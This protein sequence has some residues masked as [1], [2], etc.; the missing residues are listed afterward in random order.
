M[1]YDLLVPLRHSFGPFNLFRYI[2]FRAAA[3]GAFSILLVLLIGPV[4]I[5]LIKRLNIGQNIRTEVPGRHQAKAGT[6]T[7]GG[8]L[9]LAAGFAGVLLFADLENRQIQLGMLVLL[10]LGMLGFVDDFV[11]VK[12]RRPRGLSKTAKLLSQLAL[13]LLV[14]A[15]VWFLSADPV[16]RSRSNVL[17]FKNIVV[18]FGYFYVPFVM[19]VIVAGSNAVNLTDGLDGLAAGLLTIAL[20]SYGVLCYAAGNFKLA[21]YLNIM[22]VPTG[23]EMAVFCFALAGACLGFLWF[24]AHPAQIFMGDTGSLPLGGFLALAAVLCKHEMLLPLVGGVFVM[25]AGS[26]L[27][28]VFYF[29]A[30]RG[31]RLFRMAPIHHHFELGGWSEPQV[32]ARLTILAVLF[33]LGALATLKIR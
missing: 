3:A 13:A 10:W 24:N 8:L 14:G 7:M 18:E 32:V 25:E 31:R 28:Q 11:K 4:M 30:T 26:V 9:I 20:G 2:T 23:G 17:L 6:P 19:L 29:R 27:L 16:N 1:L 15:A 21:R 22:F 33:A 12:L 5:R